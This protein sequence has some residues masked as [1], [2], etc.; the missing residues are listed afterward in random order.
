MEKSKGLIL[1]VEDE[2]NNRDLAKKILN[3]FGYSTIAA[4]NGKEALEKIKLN[5]PELVLMDLSLPIMDGWEATAL[6]R[7]LPGCKELPIIAVTAHAMDGDKETALK[8]GCTDYISKPYIPNQLI[9]LVE[10]YL[11]KGRKG[12]ENVS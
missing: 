2:P 12:G 10:E 4:T 6:I 3:F 1:I 7:N 8:A 5:K 9:A 11:S